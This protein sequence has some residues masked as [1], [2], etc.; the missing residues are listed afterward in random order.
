[1][2]GLANRTKGIIVERAPSTFALHPNSDLLLQR[3]ELM[4][5]RISSWPTVFGGYSR[6]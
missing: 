5:T 1:M 2:I 3:S 4:L 6:F